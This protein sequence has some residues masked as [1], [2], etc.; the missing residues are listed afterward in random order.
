[1][2][3]YNKINGRHCSDNEELLTGILRNEW[4]HDGIVVTD[5]GYE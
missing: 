1:M 3:A 4:G 5:W 2:C